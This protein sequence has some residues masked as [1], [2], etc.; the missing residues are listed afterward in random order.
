MQNKTLPNIETESMKNMNDISYEI[1][2][3]FSCEIKEIMK[4]MDS[5][6]KKLVNNG[7]M[8]LARSNNMSRAE[9]AEFYL[10]YARTYLD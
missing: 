2:K 8:V 7:Y 9:K 6:T 3:L 10:N 5:K 4:Q 1:K